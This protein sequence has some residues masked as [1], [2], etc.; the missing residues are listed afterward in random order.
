VVTWTAYVNLPG[1]IAGQMS[2]EVYARRYDQTGAPAGQPFP[3]NS[4]ILEWQEY[5]DV[6]M[7]DD[8]SFVITWGSDRPSGAGAV[9]AKSYNAAGI[10][11][12]GEFRVS[13]LTGFGFRPVVAS[14]AAGNCVIAWTGG[15]DDT[16]R[17][18]FAQRF[19]RAE[20]ATASV[21]GIVWMDR[22]YNGIRDEANA[23][24][25]R[26]FTVSLMTG[27]GV[28]VATTTTDSS[29][30]YRFD[31]LTPGQSYYVFLHPATGLFFTL[32]NRGLN[33]ALD[34]DADPITGHTATFVLDPSQIALTWDAGVLL[35]S[36]ITGSV[37]LDSN[38]NGRWDPGETGVGN[39]IVYIDTNGDG[40]FQDDGS[41]P[42]RV[43]GLPSSYEINNLLPGTYRLG[44]VA[45]DGWQ[46][47]APAGGWYT[48]TIGSNQIASG[49]DFGTREIPETASVGGIV[50][51][52]LNGDGIRN[53]NSQEHGWPD[54]DVCLFTA[55]GRLAAATRT[56]G[57]GRYHFDN[58]LPGQPYYIQVVFTWLKGVFFTLQDQGTNDTID[59]DVDMNTGRSP[60][61]TLQAGQSLAQDAGVIVSVMIGGKAFNDLNGNGQFDPAEPVLAGRTV[62]IDANANGQ[63]DPTEKSTTTDADGVYLLRDLRPGTYRVAEVPMQGWIVVNPAAGYHIV[64]LPLPHGKDLSRNFANC[65]AATGLTPIGPEFRVNT[66]IAGNQYQP[67]SAMDADGDFVVAWV[68]D[69]KDGSSAEIHAQR[70][71]SPGQAL[72]RELLVSDFTGPNP[73]WP[74]VATDADGDFIV[75]W[76]DYPGVHVR[77][78]NAAGEAQGASFAIPTSLG[79]SIFWVDA[80]MDRHGDFVVT[81]MSMPRWSYF[82]IV[83][84]R[85]NAAGV[86]QGPALRVIPTGEEHLAYPAVAM[87]DDGAFVVAWTNRGESDW[88]L[89]AQRYSPTGEALG[90]TFLVNSDVAGFA[91]EATAAMNANGGFLIS[92]VIAAGIYARRYGPTGEALG[93]SFRVDTFPA[94]SHSPS[95]AFDREGDF[96][97]AWENTGPDGGGYGNYARRYNAAGVPSGS[98]F[99]VNSHTAGWQYNP[100]VAADD[101]GDFVVSW[102]SEDQDGSGTGVYAQRY[103]L[104]DYPTTVGGIFWIDSDGDGVRN[105]LDQP[106]ASATIKLFTEAG[107]LFA[108]TTTDASGRYRFTGL[109]AGQSYYLQF[110]TLPGHIFTTQDQGTDESRDSDADVATGRTPVFTLLPA[111]TDLAKDAGLVS[112]SFIWGTVYNDLN[113]NGSQDAD[114]PAITDWTVFIDTNANGKFDDDEL[115]AVFELDGQYVFGDLRPGTYRIAQV[116]Q[117]GWQLIAPVAGF[118]L[119]TIRAGDSSVGN[120]FAVRQVPAFVRGIVWNDTDADN[121]L[122]PAES[123]IVGLEVTLLIGDETPYATT[124]TD[125]QG[126]YR[127]DGLD[128]D[129]TYSLRFAKPPGMLF[130][131]P[132]QG[133]D[134][135][136][137][138]DVDPATGQTPTFT[139]PDDPDV[140]WDAGLVQ[141]ADVSGSVFEDSNANASR[142]IGEWPLPGWRFFLDADADGELDYNESSALSDA[143]GNF[144]FPSVRPGNY[145]LFELRQAGWQITLPSSGW[146]PVSL[147]PGAGLVRLTFGNHRTGP[148]TIFPDG[149]EFQVNS[150]LGNWRVRPDVAMDS[151]GDSVIV[152][153]SYAQDGD[154]GGIYAQRYNAPGQR[155]GQ[156]FRVNTCTKSNQTSPAVAMDRTGAFVVTWVSYQQSGDA[157][158]VF[159]QRFDAAGNMLGREFCVN[160]TTAG[161]QWSADVAM[162]DNGAFVVT[163]QTGSWLGFDNE[164]CARVY[165][166]SGAP[167]T[168]EFQVNTITEGR[169]EFPAVAISDSGNFV[170]VWDRYYGGSNYGALSGRR[171]DAA[172]NPQGGELLLDAG[173]ARPAN[174]AI[175]AA[176][177]FVVAWGGGAGGAV[178]ARSFA[179]DGS[180]LGPKFAVDEYRSWGDLPPGVTMNDAGQFVITWSEEQPP[181]I[182]RGIYAK[183]YSASGL[184]EAGEFRVNTTPGYDSEPAVAIDDAG[185]FVVAWTHQN[186]ETGNNQIYAQR[187]R[188]LP[189]PPV[190]NI[191]G[192][193]GDDTF[194][195]TR[196]TGKIEIRLNGATDPTWSVPVGQ[197]SEIRIFGGPGNDTFALVNFTLG[198]CT[199]ILDGGSGSELPGGGDRVVLRGLIGQTVLSEPGGTEPGSGRLTVRQ[200]EIPYVARYAVDYASIE[201]VEVSPEVRTSVTIVTPNPDDQLTVLQDDDQRLLIS[202]T[203]GGVTI[204]SMWIDEELPSLVIDV[205]SHDAGAGN[206]LIS[207]PAGIPDET[208]FQIITGT[209]NNS[210]AV[211]GGRVVLPPMLGSFALTAAGD[212]D[213]TIYT[214]TG[215]TV[216]NIRDSAHV[217]VKADISHTL[218]LKGLSI[219]G[220]GMLDLGGNELIV[221]ITGTPPRNSLDPCQALLFQLSNYIAD[222][223]ITTTEVSPVPFKGL[224]ATVLSLS[225]QAAAETGNIDPLSIDE[226][227]VLVKYTWNGDANI[228]GV[229]NADDYFQIDSGFIS[230]KG[231]W[232]NGDFNYDTVINAD[233]YFLI[234]S[235]FIGQMGPLSVSR[236]EAATSANLAAVK[237]QP[238]KE[239]EPDGILSQLFSTEP[240]LS[241]GSSTQ[242]G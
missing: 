8:G 158:D 32:Q 229:V 232:Y 44:L 13:S 121:L 105:V 103:R 58:L 100:S 71:S 147:E 186:P 66:L 181:G 143:N 69:P 211:G 202:G 180:A 159:A 42:N 208:N 55:S 45:R 196:V 188:R 72:G 176:G 48:I 161:Y 81:W 235:A 199:L 99:L 92:W 97:I 102:T 80:T 47:T 140:T 122:D 117:S 139:P 107:A 51:N 65:P 210:V 138:S 109:H 146:Y 207:I 95:V 231:G 148:A 168:G 7:A 206:D 53:P 29:G 129:E 177:G 223:R 28:F 190:I 91:Q 203:S 160:Q 27:G 57:E 236:A 24:G 112:S 60:V 241:T 144:V 163:W 133:D 153:S 222:A 128:P 220:K 175:D 205:A 113:G 106:V 10:P 31:G 61:F 198:R 4:Y 184:P 183:C 155:V 115:S 130:C 136:L 237:Q 85:F 200:A 201:R 164:I 62:F 101:D 197:V 30:E 217:T 162:A 221:G 194:V 165:D 68:S 78:Y 132:D 74:H 114:E 93:S 34:S 110:P 49:Y 233:D 127:F 195:I 142:D 149:P 228:D 77:R 118:R 15:S 185:S 83:T 191:E 26:G 145:R 75:A 141:Q 172:G 82:E 123:G 40:R 22:D 73:Q 124:L 224:G 240:V 125:G 134:D 104:S 120:D 21:G 14:D 64:E 96:V 171:F 157:F 70:Y 137:D 39:R 179:G 152:W 225:R 37:Y 215:V 89:Y 151:D 242:A 119:V 86:P 98:E 167:A 9:M 150:G 227:A 20:I 116:L 6:A 154:S 2:S 46:Q 35:P 169:Q 50:W 226:F 67:S 12:C 135:S 43:T 219:S 38:G 213:V 3:V 90:P 239:A 126:I 25:V 18:I 94:G 238:A 23:V 36:S 187:Y 156:E 174:V 17:G 19:N 212:S 218:R 193:A 209:G 88:L 63:L 166:A 234:D 170:I 111:Q 204:A 216:L 56:N 131:L 1:P 189:V 84:Q 76:S 16:G 87:D 11:E 41:E 79:G 54:I 52:D 178:F 182:P 33:D 230:Q 59:S 173:P 192:T 108:I 5:P 214:D